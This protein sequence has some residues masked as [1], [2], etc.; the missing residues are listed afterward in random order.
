MFSLDMKN[1]G[2]ERSHIL[3]LNTKYR[4]HEKQ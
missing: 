2:T 3:V 1:I 4:L